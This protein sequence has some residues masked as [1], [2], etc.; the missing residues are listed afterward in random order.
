VV[1]PTNQNIYYMQSAIACTSICVGSVLCL[2]IYT[3]GEERKK[4]VRAVWKAL[5]AILTFHVP[6]EGINRVEN[7]LSATD[8][9]ICIISF[10]LFYRSIVFV[11]RKPLRGIITDSRCEINRGELGTSDVQQAVIIPVCT[12]YLLA[13]TCVL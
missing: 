9:S 1:D 12:T 11:N 4:M 10:N 2:A 3:E 6:L 7:C 13:G 8:K 5:T